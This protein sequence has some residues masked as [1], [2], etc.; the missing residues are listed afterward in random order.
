MRSEAVLVVDGDFDLREV[1]E[2]VLGDLGFRVD[3]VADEREE[4][5]YLDH[6]PSPRVIVRGLP[7][8]FRAAELVRRIR[9]A[10]PGGA[11]ADDA[12]AST[13]RSRPDE[14]A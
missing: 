11:A 1:V 9:Q 13:R 2:D 14:A 4:R 5:E 10:A 6:E 8:P 12:T 3:W 7:R